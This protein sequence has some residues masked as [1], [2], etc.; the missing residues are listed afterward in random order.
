MPQQKFKYEQYRVRSW[1]KIKTMVIIPNN[2]LNSK[3][4]WTEM[5]LMGYGSNKLQ[6]K[7]KFRELD[8]R[9]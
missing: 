9:N 2:R 5:T 1:I 8:F 7:P 4:Q 3:G 6:F